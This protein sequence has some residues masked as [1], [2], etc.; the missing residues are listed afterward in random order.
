ME[1]ARTPKYDTNYSKIANFKD[2]VPS[3]EMSKLKKIKRNKKKNEDD[4]Y[5]L[6][7][8]GKLVFNKVTKTMQTL[9][10]DEIK[11]KIKAIEELKDGVNESNET[12][13]QYLEKIK[14]IYLNHLNKLADLRTHETEDTDMYE[15]LL[16]I[17]KKLREIREI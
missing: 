7:N 16:L 3:E 2:F 4:V 11:D 1:N 17:E 14:A 13:E 9:S 6:A 8:N 5:G 15:K 10:D 12:V